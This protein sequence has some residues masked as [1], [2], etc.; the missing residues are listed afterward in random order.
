MVGFLEKLTST[1]NNKNLRR[2]VPV[3]NV[4]RQERGG[5]DCE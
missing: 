5:A 4:V 1:G 3:V 2:A